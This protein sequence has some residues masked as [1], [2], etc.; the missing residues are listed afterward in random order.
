MSNEAY[1]NWVGFFVYSSS[2]A[3]DQIGENRIVR[4]PSYEFIVRYFQFIRM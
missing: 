1:P 4:E 2:K 3:F